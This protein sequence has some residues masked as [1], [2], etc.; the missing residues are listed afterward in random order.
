MEA[1]SLFYPTSFGATELS[2]YQQNG[3]M[4][5]NINS[6]MKNAFSEAEFTKNS[7]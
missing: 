6:T 1:H 2:V 5:K 7:Y 3:K 4:L